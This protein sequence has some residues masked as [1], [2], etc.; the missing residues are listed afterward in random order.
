M[1]FKKGQS[2]N[3]QGRPKGA[4]NKATAFRSAIEKTVTPNQIS[5]TMKALYEYALKGDAQCARIFLEYSVGKPKQQ[6]EIE[7]TT[8]YQNIIDE[9]VIEEVIVNSARRIKERRDK[10]RKNKNKEQ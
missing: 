1:R 3:P 8:D 5:K 9:A 7:D 4:L 2:G 10:T 6:I